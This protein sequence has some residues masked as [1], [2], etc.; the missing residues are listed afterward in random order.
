MN[1]I[2]GAV[3]SITSATRLSQQLERKA[4]CKSKVVH[5]PNKGDEGS[6][7]YSLKIEERDL[8]S[9]LTVSREV[10]IPVR[11]FYREEFIDG[12]MTYHVIPG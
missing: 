5:T 12:E 7:S 4:G 2:L 11:K 9:L 10:R 6:C 8:Q 3:G 1:Y